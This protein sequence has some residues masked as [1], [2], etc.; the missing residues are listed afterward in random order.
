VKGTGFS[1]PDL[2][3]PTLLSLQPTNGVFIF[4]Q[5]MDTDATA[6]GGYAIFC[7]FSLYQNWVPGLDPIFAAFH[8]D[9]FGL[10]ADAIL[11]CPTDFFPELTEMASYTDGSYVVWTKQQTRPA[12]TINTPSRQ[13][14][15]TTTD[16][17]GDL[18]PQAT[19]IN[20]HSAGFHL[21]R[22]LPITPADPATAPFSYTAAQYSARGIDIS[23]LGSDDGQQHSIALKLKTGTYVVNSNSQHLAT[24]TTESGSQSITLTADVDPSNSTQ[25][26]L[27]LPLPAGPCRLQLIPV[28]AGD[29][30][31]LVVNV[32]S[33]NDTDLLFNLHDLDTTEPVVNVHPLGDGKK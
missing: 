17:Q 18:G 25:G 30:N 23:V 19:N 9:L 21:L 27:N 13:L 14:F 15:L 31:D 11:T 5:S 32:R 2:H 20:F 3:P 8:R 16:G 33:L 12:L 29:G 10:N 6:S 26:I 1:M 24:I 4:H 7:P 22:P 28:N